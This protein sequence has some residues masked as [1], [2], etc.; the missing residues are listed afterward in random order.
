MGFVIIGSG[1]ILLSRVAFFPSLLFLLLSLQMASSLWL[2]AQFTEGLWGST[3]QF[4]PCTCQ[5]VPAQISRPC[6]TP[7]QDLFLAMRGQIPLNASPP[8]TQE[9]AGGSQVL[10]VGSVCNSFELVLCALNH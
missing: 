1:L 3:G 2:G 7:G 4:Q 8:Q 5:A 6:C 9:S 10:L